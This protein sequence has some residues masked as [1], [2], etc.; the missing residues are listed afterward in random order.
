MCWIGIRRVNFRERDIDFAIASDLGIIDSFFFSEE[1][2]D[3]LLTDRNG[4]RLSQRSEKLQNRTQRKC[5]RIERKREW[6][7]EILGRRARVVHL[8]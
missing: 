8:E 4:G 5:N 2:I 6:K 7:D 1:G 3:H